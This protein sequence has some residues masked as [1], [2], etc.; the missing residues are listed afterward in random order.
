M[1][2]PFASAQST[3]RIEFLF[4]AGAQRGTTV[5]VHLGG[6][7]MPPGCRLSM[8][9][10]GIALEAASDPNRY[11][12]AVAADAKTGPHEARLSTVQGA[13][14]PF[15]FLV[16]ELPEV[17]HRGEQKPLELKLP[18]TANGRLDAAGDIDEYG[19]TLAA[20]TQ[21]V[22]AVTTR[23][24]RSPV[25]PMLRVLD[26][27][28]KPVAS[29]FPHRT[30]DAL[31]V[32]RAPAAG[33]YTLQMFDF[34]MAG[35]A[36]F[37]YRLTVTDGPWLAYAFPAGVSRVTETP[38]TVFGWNLPSPGGENHV[39]SVPP[40]NVE[41]FELTLPGCVNRLKLPVSDSP[42]QI[43]TEP[44]NTIEQAPTL[45][46]PATLN[47]RLGTPGD[48]DFASFSAKKGEKIVVDVDSANLQFA[49]DIVLTVLSEA[50]KLLIEIDDAKGS[51]DP[52]LLFTAP[53]DGRYFVSLRD[54]SRGGNAEYIYRLQLTSQQP[55]MSARVNTPSL[56]V[57][58]GQTANVAVIVDRIDGLADELEVTALDLPAGVSVKPQPV[59]AK[60]PATVQ[61]PLT[62]AETTAPVGGLIRIVV[63]S[64]KSGEEKQKTAMIAEAATAGSGSES[65]WLAISPEV[66]FTLKT[67]T[68][69]LDA[70]RTAAFPFP[71]SVTRKEGFT[72]PIQLIGVEPDRRGTLIPLTG[73]IPAGSDSGSLP[74]VLQHK[75]TEGTT[76]RSRVMGVAEVP[77]SDGKLYAVFH[78][79]PGSMSVGCQPSLL[80]MTVAPG[81]VQRS[82]GET[83]RLEVQL[84]RRTTM[85]PITLRLALPKDVVG[86]E[87]EPVEVAGDQ[88]T[89]QLALRFLPSAVLPPRTTIEIHAE[90]S[91]DGLPIYATT[92]FR[93]ESQ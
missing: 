81:I 55:A 73:E 67:T 7:F 39:L 83:Q 66:P 84:M 23:A 89:A 13:S 78:V 92:S 19:L 76:H 22:C 86:I 30:A 27:A 63:R 87:C 70:P 40:Q 79:A 18:V 48:I 10:E 93:L 32:F 21:I 90:S 80:T 46:F 68:T 45:P 4:P 85:Q 65:L 49:T 56:M 61:L 8:A 17:I 6:E 16:G 25:D 20:G 53:A 3:P 33:H 14:S 43:E 64:T 1:S 58:S 15:P 29:S 77:G 2:G 9:G 35:G 60:T 52:S 74:L 57:H 62:I 72:G 47:G 44:N 71:V 59:P 91:R 24:I 69:I 38:V 82:H 34:Q 50:G 51:R 88:K 11:R 12:F 54:R 5:D 37:I 28:G 41:R 75:V 31:L 36:D 26:A 42:N